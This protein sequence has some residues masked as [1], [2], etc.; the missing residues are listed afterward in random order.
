MEKMKDFIRLYF[1]K[2]CNRK[3]ELVFIFY[4]AKQKQ[5]K[6]LCYCLMAA[7]LAVLLLVL[8]HFEILL[9][10]FQ[11]SKVLMRI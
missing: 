3:F 2:M 9:P 5:H 1:L 4:P 10:V 6:N 11:I 8:R 7:V